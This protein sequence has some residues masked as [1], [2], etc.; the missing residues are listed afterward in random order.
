MKQPTIKDCDYKVDKFRESLMVYIDYQ[1]QQN[2]N[3]KRL[4]TI[5]F[6]EGQDVWTDEFRKEISKALK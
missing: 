6:Y 5:V 1:N 4:L 3:L 2:K